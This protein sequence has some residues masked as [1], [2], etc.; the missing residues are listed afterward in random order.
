M[1]PIKHLII[2]ML[3]ALFVSQA[4]SADLKEI[5]QDFSDSVITTIIT[6][7]FTKNKNLNPLKISVSTED[8]I[9]QLSGHVKDRQAFVDALRLAKSTRGVKEVEADNLEIKV[10]NTAFADAYITAKVEA[11]VL[12]AKVLDDESIPLVGINASTTNGIVT[13]S[14]DLKTDKS[15]TAILKRVSSVRGV[16]KV[17]SNLR[18]TANS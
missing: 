9:V 14:G 7:K 12:K 5:E 6:A 16:K 3:L 8:G 10:V 13:L 15:I 18:V 4:Q 11:A 17:I 2:S 1:R